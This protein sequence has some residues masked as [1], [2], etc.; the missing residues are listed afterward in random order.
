MAAYGSNWGGGGGGRGGG[1]GPMGRGNQRPL[2]TEPPFTVYVGNL[3]D[4]TVQGDIDTI[5]THG[6]IRSVRLVRERDTDRFK[7]FCYVEFED[8]E[9]L[10]SALGLDGA[11]FA[12]KSIRVDIAESRGPVGGRGRGRGGPGGP[13]GPPPP[14]QQQFP[15][16]RGGG[17][18]GGA[19]GGP[20]GGRGGYGGGGFGGGRGPEMGGAFGGGGGGAMGLGV[21]GRRGEPSPAPEFKQPTAEELAN[22]PRLKLQP[23]TKPKEEDVSVDALSQGMQRSKIF[24]QAKPVDTATKLAGK[25]ET[26]A[27]PSADSN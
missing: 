15:D 3:P 25:G 26:P 9:S 23:R 12:N 10:E 24:G 4:D 13:G 19:M 18:G 14:P 22:R 21:G 2:P 1:R 5:F 27:A 17:F 8:L 7:G 16:R 20:M 6:K 11:L